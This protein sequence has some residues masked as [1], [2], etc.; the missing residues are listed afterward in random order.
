MH[1]YVYTHTYTY[2]NLSS[3]LFVSTGRALILTLSSSKEGQYACICIHAHLHIPKSEFELV[4]IDRHGLDS[5]SEFL[6]RRPT[7]SSRPFKVDHISYN[8]VL[9]VHDVHHFCRPAPV[10]FSE[11]RV[12]GC[13]EELCVYIYVCMCSCVYVK[14]HAVESEKGVAKVYTHTQD[15]HTHIH[16]YIHTC[17]QRPFKGQLRPRRGSPKYCVA[18][19]VGL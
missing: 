1:V 17:F 3:T 9:C 18:F 10:V 19:K 7:S 12:T 2:L 11:G 13:G 15:I 5:D 14:F 16:T 6:Q 8:T 4:R